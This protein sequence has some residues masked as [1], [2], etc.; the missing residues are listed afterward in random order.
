MFCTLKEKA[1][2]TFGLPAGSTF[3]SP[4]PVDGPDGTQHPSSIFT[5][6]TDKQLN[7]IGYARMTEKPANSPVGKK[8]KTFTDKMTAGIVTR[9]WTH[10]A[11][12][13]PPPPDPANFKQDRKK[14]FAT[15]I[16]EG[17]YEDALG[18]Q[19]DA[20]LKWAVTVRMKQSEVASAIDSMT[21]ISVSSRTALKAALDP[22]FD[23]PADLDDVI[24]KWTATKSKFPKPE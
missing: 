7:D 17:A 19:I 11:K 2:H 20:F 4:R 13:P 15:T 23:L 6:W 8:R 21:E 24:G 10:E 1:D 18:N 12:P 16:G 3:Q 14:E 22:I 5:I 9:T